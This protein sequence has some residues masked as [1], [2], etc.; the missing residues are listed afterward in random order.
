[1]YISFEEKDFSNKNKELDLD[2]F[3][4][5]FKIILEY[6]SEDYLKVKEA[7]ADI[8]PTPDEAVYKMLFKHE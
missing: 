1:M 2:L 8:A 5:K 4:D 3:D 6:T 7:L